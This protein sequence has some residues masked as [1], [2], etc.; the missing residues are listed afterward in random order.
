MESR[1]Y[2]FLRKLVDTPGPSGYETAP[3]AVWREEAETFA[4]EVTR[5]VLGNSFAYQAAAVSGF[6]EFRCR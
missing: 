5:D 4:D 1:S 3:A 2:N 6:I